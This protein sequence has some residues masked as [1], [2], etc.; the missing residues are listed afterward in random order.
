MTIKQ[1]TGRQA[2]W[3]E[4][5]ASYFFTVMYCTGKSNEKTDALTCWEQEISLQN[6]VKAEY[7]TRAFLSQDQINFRVLED[8]GI[9]IVDYIPEMLV[10]VEAD[11]FQE[12][13]DLID[14]ILRAN[15]KESSLDALQAQAALEDSLLTLKKDLLLYN[16]QLV[17]SDIENLQTELIWEAHNQVLTAYSER[18]KTYQLLHS[19]YY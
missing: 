18:N 13:I 8:L 7:W 4:A 10:S 1:L 16:R 9:S 2:W 6:S 5:L 17:V 11:T 19:C 3:A 15:Q 14:W 12:I